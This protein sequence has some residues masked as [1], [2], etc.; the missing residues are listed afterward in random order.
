MKAVRDIDGYCFAMKKIP[1]ILLDKLSRGNVLEL[2]IQSRPTCR[3]GFSRRE[4][5]SDD[6]IVSDGPRDL[7]FIGEELEDR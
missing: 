7:H 1:D 2:C 3:G 6:K 4:N 5:P